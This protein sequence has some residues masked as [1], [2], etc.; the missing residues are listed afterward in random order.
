MKKSRWDQWMIVLGFSLIIVVA[1]SEVA[2]GNSCTGVTDTSSGTA[3]ID[4]TVERVDGGRESVF[5]CDWKA[6]ST[7]GSARISNGNCNFNVPAGTRSV[8]A[9]PVCSN[10]NSEREKV[11]KGCE[12][13][14]QVPC[15]LRN[16]NPSPTPP[17]PTPTVGGGWCQGDLPQVTVSAERATDRL[18]VCDG[19]HVRSNIVH[20]SFGSGDPDS[21]RV[22]ARR[23]GRE[24]SACISV[25]KP[26]ID[27]STPDNQNP[28]NNNPPPSNGGNTG[29]SEGGSSGSGGFSGSS[30][31][32]T[33]SRNCDPEYYT[34]VSRQILSHTP[35]DPGHGP[36]ILEIRSHTLGGDGD[37]KV[38]DIL[39]LYTD[40]E[41]PSDY[42]APFVLTNRGRVEVEREYG[43]VLNEPVSIPG[44]DG[45]WFA[46]R[47]RV[48]EMSYPLF[49]RAGTRIIF[50]GWKFILE[51]SVD[52]SISTGCK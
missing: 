51:R 46:Y 30:G 5:W 20:F 7:S 41:L 8:S 17:T 47:F 26:D 29:G 36:A 13:W 6:G 33:S 25:R 34:E 35:D 43:E 2:F 23:A 31:S 28:P 52:K 49:S 27:C 40:L 3:S 42:E 44:M 38:S 50:G 22:K 4:V 39:T 9:R 14:R 45:T 19:G 24:D 11:R 21:Y 37:Q 32:S 12:N 48:S 1:F 18:V 15:I 10:F 16:T